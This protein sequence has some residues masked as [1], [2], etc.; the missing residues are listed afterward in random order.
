MGRESIEE[1]LDWLWRLSR[2]HSEEFQNPEAVLARKRYLA[3][4]PTHIIVLK[5]MDGRIHIPCATRTPLGIIEPFRNLGGMFDLGWPYLGEVL[6]NSVNAAADQGKR[7]LIVITYHFSKGDAL[8]GCAGFN[9]DKAASIR[10]VEGIKRQV[11]EVFGAGRQTVYPVVFGFETDE[12]ALILHG[13]KD[14][15]DLSGEVPETPDGQDP[16]EEDSILAGRLAR[17][18]PDMPGRIVRDLAPLVRGNLRHIRET[19]ASGRALATEHREWMICLGRGYDFLHEPNLALIVG[20]YSPDL[21]S[22]VTRAAGIIASNMEKG[23]IPDDGFLLLASAP[24]REAGVDRMRAIL[25][26]RFLS[27]FA[28]EV[29]RREHPG[30][31]PRMIRRAAVLNW[32]TRELELLEPE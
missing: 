22:P 3:L 13:E 18:Y 16:D 32:A 6:T 27:S 5:C 14:V 21:S 24:Y 11:E 7:V 30:L 8:R 28:D 1:R 2:E 17:L 10:Y 20:P 12:D 23:R 19:R 25:K 31:Y 26:S 9:F 29:I 4:H 15:W